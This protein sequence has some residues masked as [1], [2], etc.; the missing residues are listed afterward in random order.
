M[1]DS[2]SKEDTNDTTYVEQESN[3]LEETLDNDYTRVALSLCDDTG[4]HHF[5]EE[6]T[7]YF[8]LNI[9]EDL[10][11]FVF[12]S[13]SKCGCSGGSCGYSIDVYKKKRDSYTVAYSACGFNLRRSIEAINSYNTFVYDRRDRYTYK[14]SW[15]GKEFTEEPIFVNGLDFKKIKKISD[16]TGIESTRF[17][18]DDPNSPD[19]VN[20]RVRINPIRISNTRYAELYTVE[21]FETNHFIFYDHKMV[22]QITDVLSIESIEKEG[23]EYYDFKIYD[24]KNYTMTQDTAYLNPIIYK[25]SEIN[26]KYENNSS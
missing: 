15:N 2:S 26:K 18:I 6:N 17:I 24:F 4:Q 9:Q 3:E 1:V 5:T 13:E 21:V 20:Y 10:D 12:M 14:V 8:D 11:C 19:N 25:Y 23:K 22:F 7:S 16:I